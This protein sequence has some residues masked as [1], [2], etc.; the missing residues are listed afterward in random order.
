MCVRVCVCVAGPPDFR[1]QLPSP[2]VMGKLSHRGQASEAGTRAKL[3]PGHSCWEAP[4]GLLSFEQCGGWGSP[5][6]RLELGTLAKGVSPSVPSFLQGLVEGF[7]GPRAEGWG[8][9]HL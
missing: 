4:T 3:C 2:A 9:G 5:D 8:H 1:D 6:L 7:W